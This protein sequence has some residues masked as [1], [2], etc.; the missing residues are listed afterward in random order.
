MLRFPNAALSAA[1]TKA[2]NADADDARPAAIGKLHSLVTRI[3][4]RLRPI[5]PYRQRLTRGNIAGLASPLTMSTSAAA[6]SSLCSRITVDS[7]SSV[8]E[9]E[10]TA[11]RLRLVSLFPQYLISAM[12]GC[13]MAA[14]RMVS[15]PG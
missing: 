4:G 13:A 8:T 7:S 12:F 6:V 10:P 15:A 3:R 1:V 2:A 5:T 14:A 9:I 11:G